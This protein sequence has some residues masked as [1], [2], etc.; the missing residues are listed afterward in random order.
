MNPNLPSI[1][2]IPGLSAKRAAAAHDLLSWLASA[3]ESVSHHVI[4]T[5]WDDLS[6]DHSD[7]DEFCCF[8]SAQMDDLGRAGIVWADEDT[9]WLHICEPTD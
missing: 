2:Q 5:I 6:E 8:V 3:P 9:E 1:R 4:G 7:L